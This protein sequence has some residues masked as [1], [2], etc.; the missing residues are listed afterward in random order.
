MVQPMARLLRAIGVPVLN[1]LGRALRS[2][3]P[4]CNRRDNCRSSDRS[5]TARLGRAMASWEWNLQDLAVSELS[6]PANPH[7]HIVR[8]SCFRRSCGCPSMVVL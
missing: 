5:A 7:R 6:R 8:L 3:P 2:A 4:A 1:L